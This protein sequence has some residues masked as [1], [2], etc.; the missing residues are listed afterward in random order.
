MSYQLVL[1]FVMHAVRS[2]QET[3][4]M[5]SAQPAS[6]IP[7]LHSILIALVVILFLTGIVLIFGLSHPPIHAGQA[8]AAPVIDALEQDRRDHRV[9]LSPCPLVILS[10]CPLPSSSK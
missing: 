7:T 1:V 10:S 6:S 3:Y 8:A 5:S 2:E 4:H 9:P